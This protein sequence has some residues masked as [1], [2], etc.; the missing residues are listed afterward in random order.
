[1]TSSNRAL[2]MGDAIKRAQA[3]NG[4]AIV[5]YP[6]VAP[7]SEE[8]REGVRAFHDQVLGWGIMH[9]FKIILPSSKEQQP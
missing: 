8:V 2:M 1:M 4:V 9:Q 7:L 3:V 5:D 6:P